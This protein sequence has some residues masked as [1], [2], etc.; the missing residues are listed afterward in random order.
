MGIT[1][2]TLMEDL[3]AGSIP[4][5]ALTRHVMLAILWTPV[6]RHAESLLMAHA[7]LFP[8]KGFHVVRKI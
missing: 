3:D 4:V 7:I 8:S 5:T 2:A 1:V 6:F